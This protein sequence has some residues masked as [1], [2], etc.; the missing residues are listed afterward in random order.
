VKLGCLSLLILIKNLGIA[1]EQ[2]TELKH[3]WILKKYGWNPNRQRSG[4]YRVSWVE[5]GLNALSVIDQWKEELTETPHSAHITDTFA[6]LSNA[7]T[8]KLENAQKKEKIQW[9]MAIAELSALRIS[10]EQP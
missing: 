10:Y 1:D 8:Y 4:D 5:K 6:Q 3:E 7:L 2:I 9:D